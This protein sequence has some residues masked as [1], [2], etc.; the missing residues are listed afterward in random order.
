MAT[1][2]QPGGAGHST[3]EP[4][5]RVLVGGVETTVRLADALAGVVGVGIDDVWATV[6][7]TDALGDVAVDENCVQYKPYSA[8]SS[9]GS[10]MS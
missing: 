3:V 8:M 9:F 10:L 6:L 5:T 2:G 7:P 4:V 1:D